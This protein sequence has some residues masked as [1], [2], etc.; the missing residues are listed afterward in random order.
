MFQYTKNNH[1]KIS[2]TPAG[3]FQ[4]KFGKIKTHSTWRKECLNVAEEL[5]DLHG[6]KL[7][8]FL[9]GG[10]DSEVMLNSFTALK[11]KPKVTVLRYERH[12]NLHDINY[13]FR[14]CSKFYITPNVID[15]NVE[16]FY[17]NKLIDFADKTQCTSPQMNLIMHYAFHCNG[18][19]VIG[20]GENFLTRKIG[21]TEIYDLEMEKESKLYTFFQ[22]HN[23]ECIPAFF[24]YTPEQMVS[25][26]QKEFVYRW[27]ETA[28]KNRY[29]STK[30]IKHEI[31]AED[32]DIEMRPKLTGFELMMEL[33]D[34]YRKLLEARNYGDDGEQYTLFEDYIREFGIEPL[35]ML[36]Y[37]V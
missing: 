20:T 29:F 23:R 13:I 5:Y 6:N 25:F 2:R 14:A 9:S 19:P 32:F 30:K 33:D 35:R 36:K 15:V 10:I 26:I 11:I 1:V 18:I 22:S 17:K 28:K 8:L 3:D 24:Q 4:F 7:E 31:I 12:N 37:E 27:A 16:E 21:E 34:E